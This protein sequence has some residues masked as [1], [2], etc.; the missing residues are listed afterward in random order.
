VPYY[1]DTPF[2]PHVPAV[3]I[4]TAVAVAGVAA[5]WALYLRE[6]VDHVALRER[7]GG[8]YQLSY[9]RF[10]VDEL[11]EATLERGGRGLAN[12]F[13]TFDRV[14][15]D[16]AVNGIGRGVAGLATVGR[17]VQTGYVRSYALAVAAG[18]VL[19]AAIF[20]GGLLNGQG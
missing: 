14:V 12:A 13:T 11:Y 7:L 2:I 5:A 1:G 8:F 9:Q 19:L 15:V 4:V 6:G 20:L 3:A 10:Y 16:G 18:T 17:R